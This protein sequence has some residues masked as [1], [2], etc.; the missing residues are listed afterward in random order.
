MTYPVIVSLN[1]PLPYNLAKTGLYESRDSN[2][3]TT[4][5]LCVLTGYTNKGFYLHDP[6]NIQGY[7]QDVFVPYKKFSILFSSNGIVVF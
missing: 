4:G 5:H 1:V 6:R 2:K 7:A 3:R